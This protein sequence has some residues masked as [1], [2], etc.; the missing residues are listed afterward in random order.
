ML[1]LRLGP[2]LLFIRT[3][4]IE[5]MQ[6]FLQQELAGE[7]VAFH[8]GFDQATEDSTMC[9]LTEPHQTTTSIA[10]AK[11]ILLVNQ[12]ASFCLATII[13]SHTCG[14][15]HK[16]EMGPATLIMRIAG[17]EERILGRLKAEFQGI[18]VDWETAIQRGR[19]GHTILSLT[20][21]PI[22]SKLEEKD[23]LN[24]KLLLLHPI[25]HVYKRLRV[26]GLRFIT[27]SLE[28]SQWYELR[29]NIYDS[30]GNYAAHYYRL[31][32][33][34][35]KLEVG[36]IL[37]ETWTRDHALMMLSVMA[38]QV[39]LFTFHPPIE[40]KKLLMAMEFTLDGERL[41]DYDL[42]YRNK[43]I[44]WTDIKKKKE[45]R[46]KPEECVALRHWLYSKLSAEDIRH[47]EEM[48]EK[49]R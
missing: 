29:I 48:E 24:P 38:F 36:M 16:V 5:G 3:R 27:Q 23:L 32:E 11:K 35:S 28:S 47:L 30:K 26:E 15:V 43:K 22:N 1:Y 34:L 20:R 4:D 19:Q 39:R 45:R 25:S 2:R 37:G 17:E 46:S 21:R 7:E 41:V 42:Y 8:E 6:K 44:P 13:N 40:V 31:V 14:L 18:P 49:L 33:I 12:V 9:F 10:E